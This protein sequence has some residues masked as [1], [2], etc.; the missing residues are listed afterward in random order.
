M[1]AII[2]IKRF[3]LLDNPSMKEYFMVPSYFQDDSNFHVWLVHFA[4]KCVEWM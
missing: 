4:T 1:I 3:L 2:K